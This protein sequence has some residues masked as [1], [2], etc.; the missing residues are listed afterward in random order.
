MDH[1]AGV[2][3]LIG[4]RSTSAARY[5]TPWWGALHHETGVLPALNGRIERRFNRRS[6]TADPLLTHII[7]PNGTLRAIM[8]LPLEPEHLMIAESCALVAR[9]DAHPRRDVAFANPIRWEHG[10]WSRPVYTVKQRGQLMGQVRKATKALACQGDWAA[11]GDVKAFYSSLLP[12]YWAQQLA[13]ASGMP[14]TEVLR[15]VQR[16]RDIAVEVA[17]RL[18]YTGIPVGPELADVVGNSV[19]FPM[20]DVLVSRLGAKGYVRF[21]DDF[22]FVSTGRFEGLIDLGDLER[23][24]LTPI[25]LK[26]AW[27]KCDVVPS[28][29][30]KL[31]GDVSVF[32][33]D[34][35]LLMLPGPDESFFLSRPQARG[36]IRACATDG[37][38]GARRLALLAPRLLAARG[39]L[40]KALLKHGAPLPAELTELLTRTLAT[41]HPRLASVGSAGD[42]LLQLCE[43]AGLEVNPAARRHLVSMA[44]DPRLNPHN[45]ASAGWVLADQ[46]GSFDHR[47]L[48]RIDELVTPAARAIAGAAVQTG[49]R[50]TKTLRR[51]CN[52]V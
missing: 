4:R 15:G 14:S 50:C 24:F 5:Y 28:K 8:H 51:R 47:I 20:D 10:F 17:P 27:E 32:G 9:L 22:A 49:E 36:V 29:E 12:R 25:G 21:V 3:A 39:D 23:E 40:G 38:H 30:L 43:K 11:K 18:G 26:L 44:T 16:L 13:R 45:V 7:K 46:S 6:A 19:L 1:H 37:D 31:V 52:L 33:D 42:L 34:P 35:G 48:A 2:R 41:R